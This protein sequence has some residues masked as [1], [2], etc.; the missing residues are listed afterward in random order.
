[1]TTQ[2]AW[3][4]KD[5]AILH[6]RSL[7]HVSELMQRDEIFVRA[8]DGKTWCVWDPISDRYVSMPSYPYGCHPRDVYSR[9]S[10]EGGQRHDESVCRWGGSID[11]PHKH[12]WDQ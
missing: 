8:T 1:M 9:V 10:D 2:P 3:L 7:D 11:E 5:Q 4:T 12:P 6:Q